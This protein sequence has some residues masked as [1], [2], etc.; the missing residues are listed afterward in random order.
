ME[1]GDF[2]DLNWLAVLVGALAYWLVGALWYS[3]VLFGKK[4]QAITGITAENAGSPVATYLGSLIVMFLQVTA[5]AYLAHA[6]GVTEIVDALELG[7]G[8][9]VGF[10]ALQLLL[11]QLYEK[12]SRELLAINAGYAIVGLT[13]ASVIVVLWD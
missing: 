3:P 5:L 1:L 2:A 12:R 11:N 9:S 6:I 13:I 7:L 4:W 8:I 10:C